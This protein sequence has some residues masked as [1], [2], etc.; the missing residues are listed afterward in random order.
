SQDVPIVARS[1]CLSDEY[2]VSTFYSRL[3][4]VA[5]GVKIALDY[6][7]SQFTIYV[8]SFNLYNF[9]TSIW[10]P[11]GS[12]I[13]NYLRKTHLRTW[14]LP[15][16]KCD[17]E[18]IYFLTT[19]II[20]DLYQLQRHSGDVFFRVQPVIS[21]HNKAAEFLCNLG[22]DQDMKFS[23]ICDNEILSE[24]VYEDVVG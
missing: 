14:L 3:N 17:I 7:V 23:D 11:N 2:P 20:S 16:D 6:K 8:P 9:M 12:E 1:K 24:I 22:S 18:K 13:S 5:L 10:N 19:N 15:E 4:G 21:I